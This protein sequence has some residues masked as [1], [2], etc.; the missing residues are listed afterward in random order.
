M[1][2]YRSWIQIMIF[3]GK[4]C[5]K[6]IPIKGQWCLLCLIT[7]VQACREAGTESKGTHSCYGNLGT[8]GFTMW[9]GE[10][11]VP[12]K[13]GECIR[14]S[15][16]GEEPESF[17]QI[18]HNESMT[19]P[20]SSCQL[21]SGKWA[22][23]SWFGGTVEPAR[24]KIIPSQLPMMTWKAFGQVKIAKQAA[25]QNLGHFRMETFWRTESDFS[26]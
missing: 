10:V 23:W 11:I 14:V 5:S 3:I 18:D 21:L 4:V 17:L 8:E 16:A 2:D 24:L 20:K 25:Q 22:L 12:G 6:D 7:Q 1:K 9:W 19:H 13:S 26:I 15:K